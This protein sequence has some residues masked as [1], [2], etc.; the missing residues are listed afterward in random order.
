MLPRDRVLQTFRDKFGREPVYLAIAPGR[1]NVLG[2]HVDYNDGFVLPAAIDR[3]TYIAFAP[4]TS[5]NNHLVAADFSAEVE[6]TL[7]SAINK[8]D[9]QGAALPG[10]ALYPAGV[11]WALSE[12]S[13]QTPAMQAVFASDVPIGAGLSSSASVE[14]AFASAW[15][16]LGGWTLPPIQR[17]LLGQKAENQ[18]VGMNCGIMDQ[19]ASACGVHDKLLLLDCRSLE[20]RTLPLPENAAIVIADTSVRRQLTSS[21]YNDRRQ[22]CEEAVRIL[23]GELPGIKALRDV[24]VDDFNRLCEKLP[25]LVAR[26]ARHIVEEIER[27]LRAIP[28]LEQGRYAEFGLIMNECHVSL[29]DLYE[30]SVPE[31]DS[32]VEIA[33]GL[34][35]CL[36]ARMTGGGFGG[37]TVNLVDKKVAAAFAVELAARYQSKTGLKSEIYICRAS[38]GARVIAL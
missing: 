5:G 38:D 10:W 31:V 20:W 13:L 14:M 8:S 15:S 35:G 28:L 34:P 19:F 22:A 23:S 21:G 25:A 11:A 1:V 33:Q 36:G 29:R 7:E 17:A 3:A 6:F 16:T 9:A 30:V 2:E 12:A 37:C 32:M 18:Y 4:S 26:R 24:S 27:T